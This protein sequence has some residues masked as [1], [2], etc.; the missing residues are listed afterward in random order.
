MVIDEILISSADGTA[1][2]KHVLPIELT[3]FAQRL[4]ELDEN[5]A[6]SYIPKRNKSLGGTAQ[7]KRYDGGW[8]LQVVR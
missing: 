3:E 5:R 6:A 8:A 4:L 1:A 7:F 2:V